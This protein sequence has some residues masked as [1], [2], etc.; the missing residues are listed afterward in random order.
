M[1]NITVNAKCQ[2]EM[3]KSKIDAD[4]KPVTVF[5]STSDS[6][7]KAILEIIEKTR[8]KALE[9]PRVD[10]PGAEIIKGKNRDLLVHQP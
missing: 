3:T 9:T 7:Y 2:I 1:S 5:A 8:Q 10:M 6:A 4:G